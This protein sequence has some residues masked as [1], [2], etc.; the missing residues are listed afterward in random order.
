M[1]RYNGDFGSF[2]ESVSTYLV[3]PSSIMSTFC[4]VKYHWETL[5][6]HW[7]SQRCLPFW[8]LRSLNTSPKVAEVEREEESLYYDI[9]ERSSYH[10]DIY[11]RQLTLQVLFNSYY[12]FPLADIIKFCTTWGII[13]VSSFPIDNDTVFFTALKDRNDRKK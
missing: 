2:A 5:E 3:T 12:L 9:M 4:F 7:T 8:P 10:V 6:N 11:N 1:F 13:P